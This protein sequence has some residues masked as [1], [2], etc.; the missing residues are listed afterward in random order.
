MGQ[1]LGPRIP[2][3]AP[4]LLLENVGIREPAAV[5]DLQKL[6]VGPR[7]PQEEG[8]PRREVD[9]P[10]PVDLTRLDIGRLPLQPEQELGRGENRLQPRPH[11]DLEPFS[12]GSFIVEI[13]HLRHVFWR[14]GPPI[15]LGSEVGKDR[16]G[17]GALLGRRGRAAGE[18]LGAARRL[19]HSR[20]V[21]GTR[22]PQFGEV[23]QP[24]DSRGPA[25]IRGIRPLG[26][27]EPVLVHAV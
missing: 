21:R 8:E 11:S 12:G 20:N 13:H 6:V 2:Q 16:L 18:N 26:G 10:E 22:D 24:G 7:G 17:A 1:R 5:G 27:T 15:R 25:S 4:D 9:P 3:H 19:G 23:A 14:G